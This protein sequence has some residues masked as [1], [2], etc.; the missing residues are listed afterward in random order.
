MFKLNR[1]LKRFSE[2]LTFV[3]IF[4]LVTAGLPLNAVALEL[5]P[6]NQ[7]RSSFTNAATERHDNKQENLKRAKKSHLP[8]IVNKGQIKNE[9]AKFY[10]TIFCG[11]V[12]LTDN[13]EI[14]YSLP[15]FEKSTDKDTGNIK[16]KTEKDIQLKTKKKREGWVLRETLVGS[17]NKTPYGVKESTGKAN[18]FVGNDKSKWVTNVET[19]SDVSFGEVYPGVKL[20]LTSN[21]YNVEKIFVIMPGGE[22]NDIKVKIEGASSLKTNSS[23]EL[24][25]QTD[26]GVVKFSTP[27]AFQEDNGKKQYVPVSYTVQND[28]YGFSVGEY[29]KT[30][31]LV[32]DPLIASTFLGGSY[33]YGD[34]YE[35]TGLALDSQNNVY[36]GGITQAPNFPTTVGAFQTS[37]NSIYICGFVSKFDPSLGTLIASTFIGGNDE[38][39]PSDLKIDSN[40]N[41]YITGDTLATDFPT[42][43]GAYSRT[44]KG[45]RDIFIS[46]LDPS[47]S[48]LINSTLVGGSGTDFCNGS[49]IDKN[50]DIY[51]TGNITAYSKDFPTTHD[52]FQ[53]DILGFYEN[54]YIL[55]FNSSLTTLK[56]STFIGASDG[57]VWLKRVLVDS[58][59]NVY[60]CGNTNSTTYPTTNNA[61]RRTN[62]G[63]GVIAKLNSSLTVLEGSTYVGGGHLDELW[64]MSVDYSGNVLVAG[65]SQSSD[66]PVTSQA[67]NKT[68]NGVMSGVIT[69]F[70]SDLSKILN[71][72][73]LGG[74]DSWIQAMSIDQIGCIYVT[75]HT[76]SI[77]YPTTSD[78]YSKI[79]GGG[80]D[81]FITKLDPTLSN[82]RGSTYLG[83]ADWEW[84]HKIALDNSG[85]VLISGLT[86]SLDF[87]VT[88]G[89]YKTTISG[90]RDLF[91]TKIT[92]GLS[93]SISGEDAISIIA[94]QN[95]E[96][97]KCL[98]FG[99]PV[100]VATGAQEMNI[101]LIKL[102][103]AI[104][105]N[106][107]LEYNSLLLKEGPVG[108]GWGHNYEANLQTISDTNID[109]KWNANRVNHFVYSAND[110]YYSSDNGAKYD[111]LV[112]NNDNTYTL[113]RKDQSKYFFDSTGKLLK[114][115]NGHHQ[116]LNLSYDGL[117]RLNNITEPISGKY[118]TVTYNV[119]GLVSNVYESGLNRHIDFDYN[120]P[121]NTLKSVS[122][123]RGQNTYYTYYPDDR[124]KNSV[125]FE[126]RQLFYNTY[127]TEGRVNTQDEGRTDNQ[128]MTFSYDETSE[129]GKLISTVKNRNGETR[130]VT[131]EQNYNP[132]TIED[133]LGNIIETNT[134]YDDG[135]LESKTDAYGKTTYYT[136]DSRGNILTQKDWLGRTTT[137]TYY[138]TNYLKSV[139]NAV[140]ESV[141]YFY[142]SDNNLTL[143]QKP[144]NENTNYQYYPDTG[145]LWKV[146]SPGGGTTTYTYVAGLV[147]TVTDAVNNTTKYGYDNAG[148]VT[149]ITV[150][151]NKTTNYEYDND[152][153]L[154]CITDPLTHSTKYTYDSENNKL[155][156]TDAKNHTTFYAYTP[157]LRLEKVTDRVYNATYYQ[158]DG[159]DRLKYLT[160][161]RGK[162]TT[163]NYDAKGRLFETKDP[164]NRSIYYDYDNLD[165]LIGERDT[166]NKQILKID[167]DDFNLTKTVTDGVY[168]KT[169]NQF[170]AMNRLQDLTDPMNRTT[171]YT[172]DALGRLR[173]VKDPKLVDS[174]QNFNADD[175]VSDITD[176]NNNV[177]TLD[178]YLNGNMWHRTSRFGVN[179]YYYN[180]RNLIDQFVN[181]RNQTTTYQYYDDGRVHTTAD[182]TRTITYTYD[183]NGNIQTI[184]DNVGTISRQYDDLNR[185]KIYTDAM[186]NTIKYDYDPVGN[187]TIL[188]YPDNKQVK[189]DY[190]DDNRLKTVTDW[191]Y[192]TTSY[193]YYP[194]GLLKDTVRPNG[195]KLTYT[196]DNA[197]Q[198]TSLVDADS[199]G[200]IIKQ[201]D[202]TYYDDGTV[203]TEDSNNYIQ[204][205]NPA[206]SVMT[207]TYDN[208]LDTF[209]GT[210]VQYDQ[211]GNMTRGPLKGV[212]YDFTFDSRNRLISIGDTSYT[213]DAQNNR[214]KVSETVYGSTYQSQYVINPNAALSQVLMKTDPDGKKT[215]YVYGLGLIGQ[216]QDGTYLSYHFDRRGST[217]ALTNING[218]VTDLFQYGPYGEFVSQTGATKTPFL[219]NGQDG[220]ITDNN[221]LY[222]M[223]A[224]YY[225]PDIKRFINQDILTGSIEKGS[226]LNR[227][228]YVNGNPISLVDPFGLKGACTTTH[229]WVEMIVAALVEGDTEQPIKFGGRNGGLGWI[230]IYNPF[231][232]EIW[233]VKPDNESYNKGQGAAQLQGYLTAGLLPENIETFGGILRPGHRVFDKPI[234]LPY[235]DEEEITI[236]SGSGSANENAM[237]YYKVKEKPKS[238]VTEPKVEASET[239]VLAWMTAALIAG[240]E[241]A[242]T[243]LLKGALR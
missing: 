140:Y 80:S 37:K 165:R 189:Y 44:N 164:E 240:G 146:I 75:G 73:F 49:F 137:M 224:R 84:G 19:Y 121:S 3:L 38:C 195:T 228:A 193:Y 207:Y 206:S 13:G 28:Q 87:P 125:D 243:L 148:R 231:T 131:V 163:F 106:F 147:D 94:T 51:I 156:E 214:I 74:S 29:D 12:F 117:G 59:G 179:T 227:Y 124:I 226:T 171:H 36:V 159:E 110:I 62:S 63:G 119:Y 150:D 144:L 199:Q 176:P 239:T 188:T 18:Y 233:E 108:K 186:G 89:S 187:L 79:F 22:S 71:S 107:S 184:L 32:I 68:F 191:A 238:N 78:A 27:L 133:E 129:P 35:S 216:E 95:P 141:Y 175:L 76:T 66:Y 6:T 162:T 91:I 241:I 155:T 102:N 208:R 82:I 201:Y 225:N 92:G 45:D 130:V 136:Y 99:E 2:I 46:K 116:Y 197:G 177:I 127:D 190:Y 109:L 122:N 128:L 25:L 212:F 17:Q 161:A 26:I 194:N 54:G 205:F 232:N 4:S 112:K 202:Y 69:R 198:L 65:F 215:Y 53:P 60:V 70:N 88:K 100:D 96:A 229:N 93:N 98:L 105:I 152:D 43:T 14:V 210:Q 48:N 97:L 64:D 115:D 151:G 10:A 185:V 120:Y 145:M 237:I 42:T 15:K 52:G 113:T 167:Y 178:Y 170:D 143:V 67:Y 8:F 58:T 200:N 11:S 23:G 90:S 192:R 203:K 114:L 172:Y 168:R 50:G 157:N 166:T 138:D 149:A 47:L 31:P 235:S 220:V 142:N 40:G 72:T 86:Y 182:P 242:K 219:Y 101:P 204:P 173:I 181:A 34:E 7:A 55:K 104:P 24:E 77:D 139:Q 83:G 5:V 154:T 213:Y 111:T 56:N 16:L 217:V 153:N 222:F 209:N 30:K 85:N 9:N 211:D 135:N 134:Y 158:Y 41:V 118:L 236:R 103:G 126:G 223:R 183:E 221:G 218:N 39:I 160:N 169:V 123:L 61:F 81:C 196:Y 132:L 174:S 234:T 180:N 33:Q 57:H 230:D 20:N 21:G 1:K